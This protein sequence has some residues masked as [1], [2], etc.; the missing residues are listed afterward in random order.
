MTTTEFLSRVLPSLPPAGPFGQNSCY[1]TLAL[2]GRGADCIRR[3][4]NFTSFVEMESF[5]R[6]YAAQGF[7]TYF[8]LGRYALFINGRKA[9]NVDMCRCLWADIDIGKK[10][11]KFQQPQ[12]ALTALDHFNRATGLTPTIIVSSGKGLHVYWT[13]T[14]PLAAKTW[15]QLATL[16]HQLCKQEG[17]DVDPTRAEDLAS[18]LRIPGTIHTKTGKQVKIV[19]SRP[20]DID[21]VAFVKAMQKVLRSAPVA[22]PRLTGTTN[23]AQY[24]AMA[25]A[26][27]V[28]APTAKAERIVRECP[29]MLTAG[30]SSY[31]QWFAA[32][33]V[34][35]RC[36]DGL[37]WAHKISALDPARYNAQDTESKFYSAAPDAPCLCSSFERINPK[38]CPKCQHY[39]QL[40]TPLQIA[41]LPTATVQEPPHKV[42]Q[43]A[44]AALAVVSG[45]H[46]SLPAEDPEL[47]KR[48]ALSSAAFV[49]DNRGIVMRIPKQDAQGNWNTEERVICRS[50]LYYKYAVYQSV[51]G[52]PKRSHVFEVEHP[53]GR[54]EELLFVIDR[55]LSSQ[56]IMHWFANGNMFPVGSVKPGVFLEFINAYLQAVVNNTTELPTLDQFGWQDYVDPATK[57]NIRGFVTGRGIVTETGLHSV[58]FGNKASFV[59]PELKTKGSLEMWKH[60]P[61]MYKTLDQKV[62][63]LAMCMS[64]AAPFMAFGSGE[65]TNGI[66]SLWSSA[67][68]LGKTHVLRFAASIWGNPYEQFIS[69]E[70]SSVARTRR[71]SILNN[72]PVF[73]DEMTDVSDEDLYSLTYTIIGGKEKDKLRS[74]GDSYVQTGKWKTV[75]FTTANRSFKDAISRRAGD[76]D[77]TLLRIME[78]ECDFRSFEN[79]PDVNRYINQCIALLK[80]NYGWAG[81]ELMYQIMQRPDRLNVLT[82]EVNYWISKHGFLNNERFMAY[83]LAIALKVGRWCV[84]FGLLDYD[85]DALEDWVLKKFVPANRTSTSDYSPDFT[86]IL[87]VYLNERQ[88]NMLVVASEKRPPNQPDPGTKGMPDPWIIAMPRDAITVR[89]ERDNKVLVISRADFTK[90]CRLHH[91]ST[92]TVL[93]ELADDGISIGETTRDLTKGISWMPA[94]RIRCLTIEGEAL[95]NIGFR[96][97]N[98]GGKHVSNS[99]KR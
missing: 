11:N 44:D 18:V 3:Q 33:S 82:N 49:V 77:A 41:K 99:E 52:Q 12:E 20:T 56:S 54:T 89:V 53:N 51:D 88:T 71:M 85:M 79:Q 66:F 87:G 97:D 9:S 42:E 90:W 78:Y 92:S 39:R 36:T 70:A 61:R 23:A 37:E 35:R 98:I 10:D 74:T 65:A 14:K 27:M 62:G 73:L 60:I 22:T 93:T 34:L 32:M 8:A 75:T 29:Q 57:H 47:A 28:D 81:P 16:F 2:K 68:G 63:Q 38:L 95:N 26:G 45:L 21:P 64:F 83:P 40:K 50:R 5:G 48:V 76:S 67:S 24:A 80:E 13:F 96:I 7:D 31:P 4:Q 55:D 69:R 86:N 25:A 94:S 6:S 1:F 17:L 59:E 72:L 84:E 19:W 30:L 91:M 43:T 46:S 58:R 15:L